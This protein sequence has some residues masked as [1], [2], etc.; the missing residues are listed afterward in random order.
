MRFILALMLFVMSTLVLHA[1]DVPRLVQTGAPMKDGESYYVT[2]SCDVTNNLEAYIRSQSR[3]LF[4][5]ISGATEVF[6]IT[7]GDVHSEAKN[8]TPGDAIAPKVVFAVSSSKGVYVTNTPST[9]NGSLIATGSD[10]PKLAYFLGFTR[11]T[12]PSGF[13]TILSTLQSMVSPVYQIVTG[14][15]LADTDENN[16]RQVSTIVEKYNAY[17]ALF[18]APESTSDAVPLKIGRNTLITGGATVV[19]DVKRADKGFL[20]DRN[21]PFTSRFDKLVKV[22]PKFTSNNFALSCKFV[23]IALSAAGFSTPDD[24]AYIIY[25][26]LNS[27]LVSSKK[28]IIDC[29]GLTTL[30]PVVMKSRNLYLKHFPEDILITAED[31]AEATPDLS[32]EKEDMRIRSIVNKLATIAGTSRGDIIVPDQSEALLK[33]TESEIAVND[34]TSGQIL[35]PEGVPV[36]EIKSSTSGAAIDQL[37]KLVRAQYTKFGCFSLTRSEP[38]L[39]GELDGATAVLLASTVATKQQPAKTVALRLFFEGKPKLQ[40]FDVTDN[41]VGEARTAYAKRGKACSI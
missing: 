6:A 14:H 27:T 39:D 41:W 25:R 29:L 33:I 26:S 3:V 30:A 23:R 36:T 15:E 20:L 37:N 17:L 21:V 11:Q 40:R 2:Y 22:T 4:G 1:K 16:L 38:S 19:V 34:N 18:T 7:N 10:G 24:Q 35:T 8:F 9:C 5:G 13:A 28:D 12:L 32:I 31:I